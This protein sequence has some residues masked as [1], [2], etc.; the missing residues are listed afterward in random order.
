MKRELFILLLLCMILPSCQKREEDIMLRQALELA[1]SNR[2]ELEKVLDYYAGDSLKLEAAKFLIR[3]MPG[4]YSYVDTA[5]INKYAHAVFFVVNSLKGEKDKNTIRDSIDRVAK[6]MGIDTLK[7]MPDCQFITADF[8]IQNID[9][10]FHDWQHGP[11]AKHVCFDD[12]CEWILPYKVEE[13]Q[14]LDNWRTRLKKYCSEGVNELSCCDQLCNSPFAA[15]KILNR[16]LSDSLRPTMADPIHY[17]NIPTEFR[18]QLPFGRCG[19]YTSMATTILRSHGIPV[20][21]QFT[22]QWARRSMGHAWNVLLSE[23]GR[24]IPFD[25]ISGKIG[26]ERGGEVIMPKI[27]RYTY[28]LNKRLVEINNSG[29][30]VP[31][32]FRNIFISDVTKEIIKCSDVTL[33]TRDVKNKYVYLH[34]FDNQNWVPVAYGTIKNNKATFKDVG[35][36]VL[37]LPA[38][39]VNNQMIPISD[40]F[41]LGHYGRVRRI[42]PNKKKKEDI[43]LYRKYPVKQ[44]FYQFITRLNDGEFQASNDPNF[45]TYYVAYHIKEGKPSGQKVRLSDTIP[46]C[47]YWRYTSQN[48]KSF[49]NIAEVMFFAKDDTAKLQGK[50]IGTDGS[51]HDNPAHTKEMVFDG[52]ILTSFD[53]PNSSGDWVGL[54]MGRPVKV[55]SIVYYGRSDGNGVE[56]GDEYELLYWDGKWKSMGRQKA[57]TVYVKYKSVPQDALYLLKNH[58][59]GTDERIFTLEDGKQVWW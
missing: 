29:E 47:R 5:A 48:K 59:K 3:N 53:A 38:I 9:T 16:N 28:S 55:N 37:Y 15:A 10:A 30:F 32:L 26:E 14:P 44:Y 46:P 19:D 8:L 36:N 41:I 23:D 11:W 54:D 40:P 58:T 27:Y 12:F 13:L 20:V 7:I 4:H 25:G 35:E 18:A 43:I 39:Y 33:K 52:D 49:C 56:I 2:A 22:P 6:E 42:V 17:A 24:K 57:K 31:N 21:W 50:V 1:G 51:W 34:V 45:N